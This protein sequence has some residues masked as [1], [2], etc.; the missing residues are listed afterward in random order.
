MPN[1]TRREGCFHFHCRRQKKTESTLVDSGH[2]SF[3]YLNWVWALLTKSILADNGTAENAASSF[4]SM[5]LLRWHTR[6]SRHRGL[7]GKYAGRTAKKL[8]F[9]LYFYHH[10]MQ[11]IRQCT[12]LA[13]QICVSTQSRWNTLNRVT[14]SIMLIWCLTFQNWDGKKTITVLLLW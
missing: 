12:A 9:W 3:L 5:R 4:I 13:N 11:T 7:R 2:Q 10:A 14:L 8:L 1:K 6:G